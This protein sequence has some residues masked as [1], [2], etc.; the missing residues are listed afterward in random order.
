LNETLFVD[1]EIKDKWGKSFFMSRDGVGITEK[2]LKDNE[3]WIV[4]SST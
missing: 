4:L 2:R 3:N 1:K